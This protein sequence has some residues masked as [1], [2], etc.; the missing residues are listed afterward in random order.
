[1]AALPR[2]AAT[3]V[4]A[5]HRRHRHGARRIQ[6]LP[7]GFALSLRGRICGELGVSIGGEA[8]F[9]GSFDF[10]HRLCLLSSVAGEEVPAPAQR[11][12]LG[13]AVGRCGFRGYLD[14]LSAG[15]GK[16]LG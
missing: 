2:V 8:V 11:D 7:A 4:L 9:T 15:N 12:C 16:R 5:P 6:L 1:M 3:A 13:A 14:L 10:T